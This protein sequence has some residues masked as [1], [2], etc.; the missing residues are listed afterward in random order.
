[1]LIVSA[2]AAIAARH[3]PLAAC[4]PPPKPPYPPIANLSSCHSFPDPWLR[5]DGSRAS[6]PDEWRDHRSDIISLLENYMYGHAPA[7]PPVRSTLTDTA[8]VSEYCERASV[9]CKNVARDHCK[10]R[11]VPLLHT[12]IL[13][14]YTLRVGPSAENLWPFDVFVYTPKGV[15][16]RVPFVVYNGE[17]FFSGVDYGDLTAQ[18]AKVLLDRGFGLALFDRTQLRK[19]AITGGC[20]VAGCGMGAPDGVQ[21]V[22]PDHDDWSTISVWAWGAAHVVDF[23]LSDATLSPLVDPGKLMSMGHS[24]G[25]KTALWHGAQDERIAITYPLMSGCSGCGAIRVPTPKTPGQDGNSQSLLDLNRWFPYWFAPTYHNFSNS[26][27]AASDAGSSAPW[28]QHFQRMLVAPRGLAGHLRRG[29]GT[30]RVAGRGRDDRHIL[31]PVRAPDERQQ[32]A[33]R[34]FARARLAYVCGL[35]RLCLR[36]SAAGEFFA[37]QQHAVPDPAAVQLEGALVNAYILVGENAVVGTV[38]RS[39]ASWYI[40]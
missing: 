15:A 20:G 34:W 37:L 13:R 6:T 8:E 1:M 39:V 17:G 4:G 12:Q 2:L 23:L 27:E 22:Y 35:C 28:D 24:R 32:H 31:S 30:V 16:R 9:M 33:V 3:A 7:Q 40:C 5:S 29:Q 38:L 19:D 10:L 14:N 11:C 26:E 36:W 18:G 25:G 21:T